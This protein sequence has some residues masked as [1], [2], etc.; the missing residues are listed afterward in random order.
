MIRF[1][2]QICFE[3]PC[4]HNTYYTVILESHHR[5]PSRGD[6]AGTLSTA[7]NDS[8]LCPGLALHLHYTA[9]RP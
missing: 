7:E 4:A 2:S 9:A 8:R 3:L 1:Y 5:G 6:D